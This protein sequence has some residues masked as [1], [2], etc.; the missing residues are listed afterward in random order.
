[1]EEVEGSRRDLILQRA[2][3][4]EYVELK[5]SD[6]RED[7]TKAESLETAIFVAAERA[8]HQVRKNA[9]E[10]AGVEESFRSLLEEL[11]NNR[12][13]T[14]QM[15]LRI[16]GL[17]VDPLHAIVEIDFPDADGSIGLFKLANEKRQNPT[18]P[19]DNSIESLTRM[20]E[21]MEKV[22]KEMQDLAEFHEAIKELKLI[23][24]DS[25]KVRQETDRE[26]KRELIEKLK[27][28]KSK[29]EGLK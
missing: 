20:L 2:K 16:K 22:L 17:I 18:G 19:I 23:I 10:T 8:L 5:G 1:M 12:V 28:T 24:D 6:K 27:D 29:L 14:E 4:Q 25:E 15:V 13:H 7:R 11:V 21:H 26:K 9:N 3:Y